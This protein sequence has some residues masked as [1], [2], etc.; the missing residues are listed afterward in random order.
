MLSPKL[1][2][3]EKNVRQKIMVTFGILLNVFVVLLIIL[4]VVWIKGQ[5]RGDGKLPRQISV[6]GE[7]K[8]TIK[9]DTARFS[10]SAITTAKRIKDAQDAN[11]ARTNAVFAALKGRGV[12]EK[13]L[14]TVSYTIE[15]Q[16]QYER[17]VP[18][19]A[20]FCPPP[21]IRPPKIVSYQVR[22]AIEV[23]A[24]DLNMVDDLL[25]DVAK[26]GANEIG[27]VAFALDNE[28][29]AKASARTKA[30]ADAKQKAEA[31]AQSLGVR[32]GKIMA[33]SESGR[34]MP[35]YAQAYREKSLGASVAPTPEL[36]PGQ[37]EITSIVTL[38]Y[39][40][41]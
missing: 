37:Q 1:S 25:D 15:P 21:A 31:L 24:R 35:L 7:G 10:V 12:A 23:T 26:A 30:I 36:Q 5:Y 18:C 8:V 3:A 32:L 29:A 27:S 2:E 14:K 13:D 22:H 41:R 38:T 40:M 20:E 39:Q 16:Y 9:P 17:P 33:F 11:T 4:S 19:F 34:D 6:A 28:E